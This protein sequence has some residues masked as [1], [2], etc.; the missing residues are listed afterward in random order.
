MGEKDS[1]FSKKM[2]EI[3]NLMDGKRDLSEITDFVSAEYG[4]TD[5]R[6][7]LRFVEDLKRI[8][9]VSYRSD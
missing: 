1:L 8:R 2:Y 5:H 6:D 7:V 3:V 9:L 4:H